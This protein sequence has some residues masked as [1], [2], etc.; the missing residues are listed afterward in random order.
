MAKGLRK[1]LKSSL[2]Y[3]PVMKKIEN[4]FFVKI[5]DGKGRFFALGLLKEGNDKD[6]ICYALPR[7]TSAEDGSLVVAA[8]EDG[9]TVNFGLIL[10]AC[11]DGRVKKAS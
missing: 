6:Y 10:Q 8:E 5:T 11:A 7:T 9:T 2:P 3:L 1:V 4:S